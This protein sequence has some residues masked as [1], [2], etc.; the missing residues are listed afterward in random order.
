V[1]IALFN[2]IYNE[3]KIPKQW[4]TAKIIPLH[5]KGDTTDITNYRPISNLC[6]LSKVFE[7][8]V[9]KRLWSIAQKHVVN[10]TSETQHGFK[11]NKSLVTAALSIQSIIS[12]AMDEDKFVVAASL[13]LSVA[14]DV[15]NRNLLF[16]RIKIMGIPDDMTELLEDWLSKRQSYVEVR[17]KTSYMNNSDSGTVQGSVLGPVLFSIF[18]RP[19]YDIEEITTYAENNYVIKESD[20]LTNA[21]RDI[22]R[23]VDVVAM[24]LKQSGLKVNK[25][26]TE[27]CVFHRSRNANI[28]I[29]LC[30]HKIKNKSN[31]NILGILFDSKLTWHDHVIMYFS[32]SYIIYFITWLCLPL[33][34]GTISS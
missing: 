3:R 33:P 20:C 17:G 22:E 5:K 28:E 4:K 30:N 8:L 23:S 9:L 12:R 2:K 15:V 34:K 19:I 26:K 7:K 16:Q 18:I 13:D 14:F 10:L 25:S 29:K 31:I 24:W 21:S 6:T 32:L 11:P 27:L 1:L